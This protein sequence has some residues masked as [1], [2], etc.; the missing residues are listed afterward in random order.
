MESGALTWHRGPQAAVTDG[1][2]EGHPQGR[3]CPL[4]TALS[5]KAMS[6]PPHVQASGC[7]QAEC[8]SPGN[9]TAFGWCLPLL[10][11][12]QTSRTLPAGTTDTRPPRPGAAGLEAPPPSLP[13]AGAGS[14]PTTGQRE[15]G[16]GVELGAQEGLGTSGGSAC[17]LR[18]R[19]C[20]GFPSQASRG[21]SCPH[22]RP[23]P[24]PS[25]NRLTWFRQRQPLQLVSSVSPP[26]S[27]RDGLGA[28][29]L[30]RCL[31]CALLH[32]PCLVP[33]LLLGEGGAQKPTETDQPPGSGLP[34]LLPRSSL[35]PMSSLPPAHPSPCPQ[36]PEVRS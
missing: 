25:T 22:A 31:L 8:F 29:G 35:C 23:S 32:K 24:I 2:S 13:H 1:A 17:S 28:Y 26:A 7:P 12:A 18:H 15:T 33:H 16:G 10:R 19:I 9:P 36:S 20:P 27:H 11:R 21:Q 30:T 6:G 34:A 5:R 4:R 3:P 14:S